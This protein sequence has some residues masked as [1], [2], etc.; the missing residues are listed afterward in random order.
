[1]LLFFWLQ[2]FYVSVPLKSAEFFRS[3]AAKLMALELDLWCF[4]G[5]MNHFSN[6]H[7][8]NGDLGWIDPKNQCTKHQHITSQ[9]KVQTHNSIRIFAR[10]ESGTERSLLHCAASFFLSLCLSI[11]LFTLGFCYLKKPK[12][13]NSQNN[14]GFWYNL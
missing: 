2:Y 4:S 1:M 9:S 7:C 12:C 8:T 10:E 6:S 5:T 14:H 13:L 11:D 3:N